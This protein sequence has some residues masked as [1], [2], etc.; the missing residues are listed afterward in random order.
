[1]QTKQK[2]NRIENPQNNEQIH[3]FKKKIHKKFTNQNYSAQKK[4]KKK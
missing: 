1:M 3:Q 4:K 2:L